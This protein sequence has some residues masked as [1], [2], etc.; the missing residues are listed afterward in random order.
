M[1]L[2]IWRKIRLC[3][4]WVRR[5][6]LV[7][8]VIFI[9]GLLWFNQIGLPDF[10]KKPLVEKLRARGVDLEFVRLR[11]HLTGGLVAENVRLGGIDPAEAPSIAIAEIQLQPDWRALLHGQF[12]LEGIALRQGRIVWRYSPTNL[13]SVENINSELRFGTNDTWSLDNF[14]AS[15]AGAKVALSGNIIHAPAMRDWDIFH[16]KKTGNNAWRPQLQRIGDAIGRIRPHPQLTLVVNGDGRDVNSFFVNLVVMQ[17]RTRLQLDGHEN[18]AD[19][20]VWRVHGAFD[21]EIIHPFL[22]TTNAIRGFSHFTFNEPV[23]IDAN[24]AG[25]LD[26]LETISASGSLAAT[27]FAARGEHADN[28]SGEFTYSNRVLECLNPQMSQGAQHMTAD[29]V[30]LDLNRKVIWIINGFST[31]DP[32]SVARAIGPKT[33]RLMEPYQFDSPPTVRV[34]G[35]APLH[36]INHMHEAD[37]AD[38]SFDVI[39]GR[40]F[41]CLKLHAQT[42]TGT[43]HWLGDTLTLTNVVAQLY[44]GSGNG[45]AFFDFG[46]QHD[47]ADYQFTATVNN[48]NV[49]QLR[50]DL[51]DTKKQ[52]GGRLSGKVTVTHGET[53][54]WHAMDGFGHVQL[55]DG[56]LW[57]EPIFGNILSP[58]INTLLPGANLGNSRATDAEAHF[59]MTNGVIYSDSL[60]VQSKMMQL[61]YDGSVDL[62]GKLHAHVIAEPLGNVPGLGDL[63]NLVFHPFSKLFE[64]NISGTLKDPAFSPTHI[65]RGLMPSHSARKRINPPL[66]YNANVLS[67]DLTTN[68]PEDM[69]TDLPPVPVATDTNAPA[70]ETTTNLPPPGN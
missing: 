47:G 29:K 58:V 1:R 26:Q 14:K 24:L 42:I 18:E 8:V 12:Q 45:N 38:L 63:L 27:N 55:R 62:S 68:L 43:V 52:L 57:D 37:D 6:A 64:Y 16:G 66:L 65:P 69:D 67:P 40:N 49:K 17:G 28:C 39:N 33:G 59:Q 31:A 30:I 54:D 5:A 51:M 19:E 25:R 7:L 15:F 2:S 32:H 36:D 3:V 23:Y 56:V 35:S 70:A 41:R 60:K 34:N 13:L 48:L 44:S 4:R 50:D 20:I 53:H 10:L 22:F 9:A 61:V 11:L 21:P 46:A